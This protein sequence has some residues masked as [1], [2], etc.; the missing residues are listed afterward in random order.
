MQHGSVRGAK[1][2]E[3]YAVQKI[4]RLIPEG[5]IIAKAVRKIIGRVCLTV[6]KIT[7]KV[8]DKSS[9]NFGKG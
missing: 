7:K 9:L 2:R 6:I 3:G 5:H 4:L 8:M 1:K